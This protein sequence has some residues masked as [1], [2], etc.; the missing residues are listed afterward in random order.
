VNRAVQPLCSRERFD[1]VAI[2]QILAHLGLPT[3][4]LLPW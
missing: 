4:P 1:Q 3:E 2:L